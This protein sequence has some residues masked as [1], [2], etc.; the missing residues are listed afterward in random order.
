MI[1]T[2]QGSDGR[3]GSAPPVGFCGVLIRVRS[4]LWNRTRTRRGRELRF[5]DRE[6]SI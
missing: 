4:G 2:I 3:E 1:L 6:R 5:G